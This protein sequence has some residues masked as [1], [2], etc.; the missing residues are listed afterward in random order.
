MEAANKSTRV[1]NAGQFKASPGGV[2]CE[3]TGIICPAIE[4][5]IGSIARVKTTN[6]VNPG[7]RKNSRTRSPARI[8]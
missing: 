2:L 3:V 6:G 8:N 1:K 4:R 7:Y 5:I